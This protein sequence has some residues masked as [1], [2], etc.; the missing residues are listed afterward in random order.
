MSKQKENRKA[1]EFFIDRE[2]NI[3]KY[4]GNEDEELASYHSE[5]AYE[6]FP[7]VKYPKDYVMKMGWVMCSSVVY[8][9][10]IIEIDPSQAQ[11]NVLNDMGDLRS[12]YI[13]KGSCYEKWIPVNNNT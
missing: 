11:I 9:C 13:N 1:V 12:L 2:G 7:N 6:L 5:I 10:H 8:K 3:H 4:T